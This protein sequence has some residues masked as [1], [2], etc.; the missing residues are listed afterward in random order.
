MKIGIE[1]RSTSRFGV[2][3][4]HEAAVLRLE[5]GMV[6]ARVVEQSAGGFTVWVE[7]PCDVAVGA[8]AQLCWVGGFSH[9]RVK[10][11]VDQESDIRLGLER[12]EDI[13]AESEIDPQASVWS[14]RR[15]RMPMPRSNAAAWV[16]GS[17][18]VFGLLLS[19]AL[20]AL[21][22]YAAGGGLLHA[23]EWRG[24]QAT[25]LVGSMKLGKKHAVLSATDT[26]QVA[27]QKARSVR[28]FAAGA[29]TLAAEDWV[30]QRLGAVGRTAKD[31]V[32]VV[33]SLPLD[34]RRSAAAVER[35]AGSL[36]QAM[37]F[38]DSVVLTLPKFIDHLGFTDVQRAQVEAIIQ[39]TRDATQDI[40]R[41]ARQLGTEAA[42]RQIERIRR[43]GS[44]QAMAALTPDQ[45]EELRSLV[46]GKRAA[47]ESPTASEPTNSP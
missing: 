13:A 20:W 28:P 45:I 31:V 19:A 12:V 26:P 35:V 24:R 39:S 44:E 25:G 33:L 29:L 34:A 21:M 7:S 1:N 16:Y 23:P 27:G 10:N 37:H 40:Y 42:M 14:A 36:G 6:L 32:R 11:R 2:P 47:R 22:P 38:D 8:S 43:E 46:L 15:P 4:E 17:L 9:V 30:S 41:Q 3:L 18:V 5:G